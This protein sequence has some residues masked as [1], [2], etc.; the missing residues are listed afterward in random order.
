MLYCRE[1]GVFYACKKTHNNF[2]IKGEKMKIFDDA[3]GSEE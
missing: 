2:H 3:N 1:F